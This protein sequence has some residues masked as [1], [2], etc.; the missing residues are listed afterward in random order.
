MKAIF[1]NGSPRK[2]WSTYQML[3][4]ASEGAKEAGAEVELINLYDY[5]F[6]GCRSCLHVSL[7]IQ[8]QMDYVPLKMI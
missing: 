1:I 6:K 5:D 8:K 4:K 3:E 2:K 7:R